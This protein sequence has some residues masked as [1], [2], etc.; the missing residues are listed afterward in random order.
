MKS[1]EGTIL[2]SWT[3]RKK[4]MSAI[5]KR[6]LGHPADK[7]FAL[8]YFFQQKPHLEKPTDIKIANDADYN[9]P[10]F[11][12]K[13]GENAEFVSEWMTIP[14]RKEL[15]RRAMRFEIQPQIDMFRGSKRGMDVDHKSPTFEEIASSFIDKHCGGKLPE[16][17]INKFIDRSLAARWYQYH[18]KH[19]VLQLLT[20]AQHKAKTRLDW[21]AGMYTRKNKRICV[22]GINK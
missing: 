14:T 7:A 2:T 9:T 18:E 22:D 13:R 11:W 17:V 19:A 5:L 10:C 12:T 8:E 3:K 1:R 20:P 4:E 16:F 6:G 21:A 15:V